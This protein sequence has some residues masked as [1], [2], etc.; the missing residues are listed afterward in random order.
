M[1]QTSITNSVTLISGAINF[2][3]NLK[4]GWVAV[5]IF[6]KGNFSSAIKCLVHDHLKNTTFYARTEIADTLCTSI[7][8]LI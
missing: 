3:V 7:Y 5:I 1:N 6:K 4:I 8:K 2:T